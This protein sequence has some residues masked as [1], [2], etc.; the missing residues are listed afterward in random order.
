MYF[1]RKTSAGRTYLQTSSLQGANSPIGQDARR[2]RRISL[3]A[4]RPCGRANVLRAGY[5]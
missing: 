4:I 1:R 2:S 3:Q 5:G